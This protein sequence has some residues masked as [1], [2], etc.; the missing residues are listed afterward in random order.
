MFLETTQCLSFSYHMYG[1]LNGMGTLSVYYTGSKGMV[2]RIFKRS[3]NQ[4]NSWNRVAVEI[5]PTNGLQV[6]HYITCTAIYSRNLFS[7]TCRRMPVN[8]QSANISI[9]LQETWICYKSWTICKRSRS[10]LVF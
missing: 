7:V 2:N 9:K 5:P 10:R 8:I 6:Y 1:T 4:G 3:G